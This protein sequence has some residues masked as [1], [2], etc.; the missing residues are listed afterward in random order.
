M[1]RIVPMDAP[2]VERTVDDLIAAG[3]VLPRRS[4][5]R[6]ATVRPL[7]LKGDRTSTEVLLEPRD[8]GGDG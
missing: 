2:V 8:P 6:R 1:A 4:R 5:P 7:A 3:L